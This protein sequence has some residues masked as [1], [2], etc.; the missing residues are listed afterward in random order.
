MHELSIALNIVDIASAAVAREGNGE[1][2]AVHIRLGALSG[3]VKE[4]LFSAF[5]IAREQSPLAS[6]QLV[7][8]D[9]PVRAFCEQ[10]QAEKTIADP[11]IMLCPDCYAPAGKVISGRE[12]EVS[13]LEIEE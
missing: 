1:V 12:L 8:E 10:C 6:A 4:A 7:V 5:D 2:S 11:P 3:V 13:A 9:V